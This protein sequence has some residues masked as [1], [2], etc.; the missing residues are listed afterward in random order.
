MRVPVTARV[1]DAAAVSCKDQR[2]KLSS[3]QA[4]AAEALYLLLSEEH[5]LG[6]FLDS[7]AA[8]ASEEL[9][10]DMPVECGITL[11]RRKRTAVVGSSSPRARLMD[12]VQAGYGEGPCL[13]AQETGST[14]LVD[15]VSTESRW[16][17]YIADVRSHGFGSVLA[18]PLDFR[19]G[20]VAAMNFYAVEAG[21]FGGAQV[22][23]AEEYASL[24]ATALRVQVRI[25]RHADAA[26][27]RRRA[28]E[29]R[30]V[31]DLALGIVMAQ[32]RCDQAAAFD[33]LTR[34]SSHRNVKIAVLA[35]DIVASVGAS[36]PVTR[37][38]V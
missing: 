9:A 1:L 16:T 27:D 33:I 11:E 3:S 17:D 19:G 25:A 13:H 5:E 23:R 29:S 15:D 2:M 7:V 34:A 31:I 21:V 30:T 35:E 10:G 4:A 12:E 26:E 37:F 20:A 22:R 18:V 28:M 36:A 14:V 6:E 8:M 24:A 32:N 38:E